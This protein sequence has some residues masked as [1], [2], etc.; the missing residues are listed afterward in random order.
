M[1]AVLHYDIIKKTVGYVRT[2]FIIILIK[3]ILEHVST[4]SL[5]YY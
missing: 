5:C 1:P 4:L 2:F 3:I